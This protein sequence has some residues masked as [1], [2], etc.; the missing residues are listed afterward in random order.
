MHNRLNRLAD[1]KIARNFLKLSLL[2]FPVMPITSFAQQQAVLYRQAAQDYYNRAAQETDPAT[3]SCDKAWG[4][5]YGCL[6]DQ[7]VSGVNVT[8]TPPT[9]QPGAGQGAAPTTYSVN[10]QSVNQQ[11]FN[12]SVQQS[13]VPVPVPQTPLA[14]PSALNPLPNDG[15]LPPQVFSGLTP[16][17]RSTATAVNS[18]LNALASTLQQQQEQ[19]V[20]QQEQ[21]LQQQEQPNNTQPLYDDN[22]ATGNYWLGTARLKERNGDLEGA[23]ADY[24]HIIDNNLP[25]CEGSGY[26]NPSYPAYERRAALKEKKGDWDGAIADYSQAMTIE[27][28]LNLYFERAEAK[29]GKHDWDGAIADLNYTLPNNQ[30]PDVPYQQAASMLATSDNPLI[31]NGGQ[32]V[33]FAKQA[34]GLASANVTRLAIDLDSLAAAYAECGDFTN[35]INT[36]NFALLEDNGP[37]KDQYKSHLALYQSHTSQAMAQK[38]H[39]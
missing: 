23:I 18:G 29:L 38:Q 16:G 6:A 5:Y 13:M 33:I 2:I 30:T 26:K 15:G 24:S 35:A 3:K 8:C 21:P 17:Q 11:Q 27:N 19:T 28:Y 37:L 34:D 20:P 14:N 25:P 9:C 32:A 10:G 12:S 39:K 31:L 4:D 1:M 22:P 7:L 36:E